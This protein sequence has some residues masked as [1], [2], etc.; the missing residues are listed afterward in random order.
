[1]AQK[2]VTSMR[3]DKDLVIKGEAKFVTASGEMTRSVRVR[4]RICTI[5]HAQR[6]QT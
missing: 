6:T 2:R 3:K 5:V 4:V 1:M